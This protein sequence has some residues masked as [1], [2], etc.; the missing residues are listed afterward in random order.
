[1]KSHTKIIE[2]LR[3]LAEINKPDEQFSL[4]WCYENGLEGVEKDRNTALNWYR[5]AAKQDYALAQ[6]H[7]GVCYGNDIIEAD[8]KGERPTVKKNKDVANL[9]LKAANQNDAAAQFNLGLCHDYGLGV[10]TNFSV[11]GEWYHKAAKRHY[12]PAQYAYGHFKSIENMETATNLYRKA[13]E[14]N[15]APAQCTLGHHYQHGNGVEKDEKQA[16]RWYRKAAE[17]NDT[18]AQEH[19]GECYRNGIGVEKNE[20]KAMEWT[21]LS[22]SNRTQNTEFFKDNKGLLNSTFKNVQNRIQT[23]LASAQDAAVEIFNN[24]PNGR[25]IGPDASKYIVGF[26]GVKD[27][28]SLT[29]VKR[30]HDPRLSGEELTRCKRRKLDEDKEINDVSSEQKLTLT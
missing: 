28:A 17:Q 30:A 18:D 22:S 6:C 4:G 10:R 25:P 19:L 3:E 16:V 1:M 9:F 13:A 24:I 15:Y 23:G 21:R 7:L 12:A 29:R 11:A 27:R 20:A 2:S 26:L 8:T 5:K 14:Q